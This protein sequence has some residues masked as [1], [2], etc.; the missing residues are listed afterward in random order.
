MMAFKFVSNSIVTL[1][2]TAFLT[3]A[4]VSKGAHAGDAFE[5]GYNAY[6]AGDFRAAL[7]LWRPLAAAG[8]ARAQYNVGVMYADG[9]GVSR[10]R[11]EAI[12]WWQR[13]GEQGH[14]DNLGLISG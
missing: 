9:R 11:A 2:L 12:R 8:E 13:A 3:T 6:Q 1:S 4:A 14:A 10:N 5:D 7:G